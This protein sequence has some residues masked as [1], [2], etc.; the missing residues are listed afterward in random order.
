MLGTVVVELSGDVVVSVNES[1]GLLVA[2]V[3]VVVL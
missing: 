1:V 2:T 3:V